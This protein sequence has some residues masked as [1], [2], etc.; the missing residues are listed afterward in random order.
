MLLSMLVKDFT[1]HRVVGTLFID[2]NDIYCFGTGLP[3]LTKDV[4]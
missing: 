3:I 2:I 1:S 4:Y